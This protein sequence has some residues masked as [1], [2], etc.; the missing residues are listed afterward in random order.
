[1]PAKSAK[2]YGLMTAIAHGATPRT[3][4]GPSQAVAKEM[5]DKTPSNKRSA[6][7]KALKKRKK[8]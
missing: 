5:V 6:F 1:M 8:K 7:M 2:Q 3:G 4:I